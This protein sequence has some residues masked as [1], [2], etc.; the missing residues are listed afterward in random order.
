MTTPE[1]ST[2]RQTYDQPSVASKSPE[3]LGWFQ[4]SSWWSIRLDQKHLL[5][6]YEEVDMKFCVLGPPPRILES[7]NGREFTAQVIK[8]LSSLLPQIQMINRRSRHLQSQ[9]KKKWGHCGL[10]PPPPTPP[11]HYFPAAPLFHA[12][13]VFFSATSLSLL[14]SLSFPP[15]INSVQGVQNNHHH[16]SHHHQ[17]QQEQLQ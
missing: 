7:D 6:W 16:H 17:E 10:L 15:L 12:L 14:C 13:L 1:K 8:D 3:R 5:R 2:N 9:G 11:S 4:K